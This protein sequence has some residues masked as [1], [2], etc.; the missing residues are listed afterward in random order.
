MVLYFLGLK[1][2]PWKFR[3]FPSELVFFLL[4]TV[5]DHMYKKISILKIKNIYLHTIWFGIIGFTVLFSFLP[6]ALS[7]KHILYLVAF[8]IC[9]P[10]VFMLTKNFKNDAKIGELS[11]PI[12]ITHILVIAI[13]TDLKM[14]IIGEFGLKLVVVSILFSIILNHFVA[15]K[16]E[17]IRKKRVA[18]TP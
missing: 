16:I 1:E 5:S 11:Y 4:G 14:N 7:L 9:L 15:D 3:F 12:Y 10:F 18:T 2:D 8:F 13:L 17:Q 6:L